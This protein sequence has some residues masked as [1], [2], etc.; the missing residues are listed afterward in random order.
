MFINSVKCLC[1]PKHDQTRVCTTAQM[2]ASD[3]QPSNVRVPSCQ[4]EPRHEQTLG[5]VEVKIHA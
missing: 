4:V 1:E 3:E 2:T 5:P